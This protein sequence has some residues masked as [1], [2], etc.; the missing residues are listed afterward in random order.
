MALKIRLR[1]QGRNN[2][3]FYRVVVTDSRSHT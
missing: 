1:Q 3:A 2:R